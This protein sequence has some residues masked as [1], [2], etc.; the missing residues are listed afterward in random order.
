MVEPFDYKDNNVHSKVIIIIG[1]LS[2]SYTLRI[3]NL[4]RGSFAVCS[5]ANVDTSINR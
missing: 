1:T 2:F 5:V 4:Y 3:S